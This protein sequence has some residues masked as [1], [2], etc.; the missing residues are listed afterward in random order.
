M[1]VFLPRRYLEANRL[2]R[3]SFVVPG[4]AICGSAG[5]GVGSRGRSAE[6]QRALAVHLLVLPVYY[7]WAWVGFGAHELWGS[8]LV[9][10]FMWAD[11]PLVAPW[12]G[13]SSAAGV[14]LGAGVVGDGAGGAASGL[15]PHPDAARPAAWRCEMTTVTAP[16]PERVATARVVPSRSSAVECRY[17]VPLGGGRSVH[18]V[19]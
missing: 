9:Y 19:A 11:G 5:R 15:A 1:R 3:G 4:R 13:A 18:G 17:S 6:L 8:Y 2:V 14:R 10:G 16:Q 12:A 7:F